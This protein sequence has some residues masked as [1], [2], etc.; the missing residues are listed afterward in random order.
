MKKLIKRLFSSLLNK[1]R[2]F[3][4]LDNGK[5]KQPPDTI[6]PLW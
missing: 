1:A 6:Y 4:K 3:F 5:D 2:R